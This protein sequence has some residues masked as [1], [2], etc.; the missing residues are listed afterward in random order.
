MWSARMRKR[1]WNGSSVSFPALHGLNN[2]SRVISVPANSLRKALGG[3]EVLR[4]TA[5]SRTLSNPK[6]R[7]LSMNCKPFPPKTAPSEGQSP[8]KTCCNESLLSN[9]LVLADVIQV[10]PKLE[11]AMLGDK[12]K[13]EEWLELCQ[14]A[15]DEQDPQKLMA[16]VAEIDRLLQAKEQRSKAQSNG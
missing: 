4:G 1:R 15:I 2:G 5:S 7:F 11:D 3:A 14:Q 10:V 6:R 12:K 8:P 9:R 16:L 13:E